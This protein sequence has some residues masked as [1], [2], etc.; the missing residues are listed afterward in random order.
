MRV[1][2]LSLLLAKTA[3]ATSY[4]RFGTSLTDDEVSLEDR[5]AEY[6]S[7]KSHHDNDHD[8]DHHHHHNDGDPSHYPVR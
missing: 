8:K 6:K 1:L 4:Q 2:F 7:K 3:A 5:I